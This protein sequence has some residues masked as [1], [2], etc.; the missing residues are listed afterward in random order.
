MAMDTETWRLV[1]IRKDIETWKWK[2]GNPDT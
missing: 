2:H 1:H